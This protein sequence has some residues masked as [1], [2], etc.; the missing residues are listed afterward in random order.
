MYD[1]KSMPRTHRFARGCLAVVLAACILLGTGALFAL[2]RMRAAHAAG[3][4]PTVINVG[5]LY[6]GSPCVQLQ[7]THPSIRCKV[8]YYVVL[9][10]NESPLWSMQLP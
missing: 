7:I 3:Q 9:K 6:I 4:H 1:P 2:D 10:I 8:V 5:P